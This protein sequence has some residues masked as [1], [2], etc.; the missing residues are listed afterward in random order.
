MADIAVH[1]NAEIN[2]SDGDSVAVSY[3]PPSSPIS[4]PTVDGYH[5]CQPDVK[6]D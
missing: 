2:H 5:C 4:P 3:K 1:L 6:L